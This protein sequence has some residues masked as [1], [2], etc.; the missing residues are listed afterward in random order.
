MYVA[1]PLLYSMQFQKIWSTF[2]FLLPTPFYFYSFP[3]LS[4]ILSPFRLHS[5]FLQIPFYPSLILLHAIH[6]CSI[7]VSLSS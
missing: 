6:M 2:L 1:K 7:V 5:V 4:S 3:P